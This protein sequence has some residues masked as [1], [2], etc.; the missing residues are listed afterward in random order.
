MP[1]K[2]NGFGNPS[3]FAFKSF[4]RLDKGKGTGA[5]GYYPGD[6]QYGSI[7]Q[8]SVI[9]KWNLDSDWVKWRKGFEIYNRA[10]WERLKI[11]NVSYDPFADISETNKPFINALITSTLFKGLPYAIQNT[12]TG[13][14]YPTANADSNTYYVVKKNQESKALGTITSIYNNAQS[15]PVNRLNHEVYVKINPDATNKSLLVQMVGDRLADGPLT[16]DNRTEATLKKVLTS[17]GLPSIYSGKTLLKIQEDTINFTQE[18]TSIKIKIPVSNISTSVNDGEFIPN[19][20]INYKQK[21]DPAQLDILNNPELLDGKVI[22]VN[23]FFIEKQIANLDTAVY[24]DDSYYFQLKIKEIDTG[25]ALVALDQGVNALPPAM[26]DLT[27]LPTIFSTTNAELTIEGSYVFNKADY[28]R[29]FPGIYFDAAFIGDKVESISYS[30]LP[31]VVKK[32]DIVNGNFIF[33]AEPYFSEINLYPSLDNGTTLVFTDNSF[34]KTF[35]TDTKWTNLDTDVDPW[36]DD[37][38]SVG[39]T[40]TPANSYSCSCPNFSQSLLSMPQSNQNEDTRKTNRQNRYPL[41]TAQS[42]TDYQASGQSVVSGK[43]NSW[44]SEAH[45][46]SFKL[47]KHTIA[48][49]FNENIK[50]REPNKYPTLEAREGFEEK[51]SKDIQATYDNFDR[52]YRRTGISISEIVFSLSKALNLNSTK[53]AYMVF[54]GKQ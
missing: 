15:Y 9:E 24:S 16:Q 45:R 37:V 3:N 29:Y 6:R 28:Q 35:T 42:Q 41:P 8:R 22:Y 2:Q 34:A 40:L 20:G 30:I 31:F 10:A 33:E 26:L 19:Q 43:A 13:Y 49:M 47:C 17:D 25:Q 27:G 51:L 12:F 48:T 23:N 5:V 4:L 18:K 11:K 54:D 7:V 32:S 1:R 46:L 38:F 50:V 52:S 14:E 39:A 44:E 36:M 21:K 53:T